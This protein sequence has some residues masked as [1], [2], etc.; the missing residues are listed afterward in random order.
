MQTDELI[1]VLSTNLEPVDPRQLT[2][3][4][5]LA[6]AAGAAAAL[7]IASLTL[8][9]RPDFSRPVALGALLPKFIFA[10]GIA[11][12][13]TLLLAR[14][15]R[16]GGEQKTSVAAAAVPFAA[17]VLLAILSLAAAPRTS[18]QAMLM[19]DTW[20]ECLL[21]ISIIAIVPFAVM[22]WVV[23]R[24]AAPTDLARS[25]AFAGLFA[26]GVSA[27]GYAFHSSEESLPF[28]ALWYGGT[29]ALCSLIGAMLGPRLLR[30]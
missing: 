2:R 18:W 1:N 7:G 28:V 11:V 5:A 24:L 4:L 26:G 29:I 17:M 13:A 12:V 22:V 8:G 9:F 30:W 23:R 25:G 6:V 21:S 15:A 19:G 16:P 14:V 20:L 27:M 10:V 3:G